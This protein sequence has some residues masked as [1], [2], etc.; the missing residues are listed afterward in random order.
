MYGWN[1]PRVGTPSTGRW[2]GR[3]A[4]GFVERTTEARK[5]PPFLGKVQPGWTARKNLE[6]LV[7]VERKRETSS[8]QLAFGPVGRSGAIGR[9][10]L[11]VKESFGAT[12]LATR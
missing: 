1:H 5:G 11:P 2:K 12:S 9:R 8:P 6:A 4:F 7:I 3:C 10:C